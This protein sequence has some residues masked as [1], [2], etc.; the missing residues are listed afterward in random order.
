MRRKCRDKADC[1]EYYRYVL[2][3]VSGSA[4]MLG[5]LILTTLTCSKA[6]TIIKH[7]DF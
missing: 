3:F 7:E 4:V 1:P 2:A 6:Q 5:I